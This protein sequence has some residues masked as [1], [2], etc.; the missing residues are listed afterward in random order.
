[1]GSEINARP[2]RVVRR[3]MAPCDFRSDRKW[4][5]EIGA[6][7]GELTITGFRVADAK[8]VRY[9][10]V[11]VEVRCACGAQHEVDE[12]NLR[13]GRTTRCDR[14]AKQ[15]SAHGNTKWDV[16]FPDREVRDAW[17]GRYC[18][19]L[20][21][22]HNPDSLGYRDYG[23][24]GIAVCDEWRYDR[25]RYFKWVSE[26]PGHEDLS[27]QLDRIDNNRGYSPGNC[28]LISAAGNMRNRRCTHHV[29][30]RGEA[31]CITDFT[32]KHTLFKSPSHVRRRLARGDTP[33]RIHLDSLEY[34]K[35]PRVR[36][37]K[38]GAPA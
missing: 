11:S 33:E 36:R 26:Q 3:S 34:G 4:F 21:R 25:S 35:S 10:L 31:M 24:R 20:S 7:Y 19:M 29:E 28:R 32:L 27:L 5:G 37:S 1:M 14:C 18:A 38:R 13:A 9:A 12:Y 8:Q 16:Y 17:I 30:F 6:R 15:A 23:G 2:S 22:C